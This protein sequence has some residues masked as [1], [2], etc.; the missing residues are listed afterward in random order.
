M[1]FDRP[2][3]AEELAGL[4]GADLTGKAR[5]E[6]RGLNEIHRV[7]AGDL[8]FADHPRYIEK[9]LRSPAS[10]VILN[11]EADCPPGKVL[12]RSEE[13]FRDFNRLINHFRNGA[14][15]ETV[16]GEGTVVMPGA[17]V[18]RGVKFGKDCIVYPGAFIGDHCIIGD[19][20][21]IQANATIGGD[22]FYYKRTAN[23]HERL[24]SCGRVILQDAVEIGSG[25][26]VDRGVT[27]DTVIGQ[28]TKLDSQ[29][30]VGHD[31]VI[32]S[33]CLFAAQVGIAGVVNIGNDVILWGQVGV[34]K[35]LTIGDGAVVLGQS[36]I[37]KSLEGH[38]TYFGSPVRDAREKMKELA[39]IKRLPELVVMLDHKD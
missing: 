34:Q 11:Q 37:A 36:G 19:R 13:P 12:L 9:A 10:A 33:H 28:G 1:R 29:V 24:M 17:H 32:G 27:G 7:E 8:T 22:A 21:I 6:V 35:D 14:T 3:S 4:I 18:G 26:T 2:H 16:K 23:G 25:C 38:R 20:V 30:H 31:T 15:G 5:T 39:Q